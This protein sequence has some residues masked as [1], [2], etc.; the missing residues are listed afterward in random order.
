MINSSCSNQDHTILSVPDNCQ[1]SK[2]S[3]NANYVAVFLREAVQF[4]KEY[5][6]KKKMSYFY[7]YNHHSRFQTSQ[8]TIIKIIKK[9]NSQSFGSLGFNVNPTKEHGETK[10]SLEVD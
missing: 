8:E 7:Q 9:K 4:Q 3:N 1:F 5:G 10:N 6:S 2:Y